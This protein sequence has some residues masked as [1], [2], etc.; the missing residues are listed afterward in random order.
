[1]FVLAVVTGLLAGGAAGQASDIKLKVGQVWTYQGAELEESRLTIGAIQD[2]PEGRIIHVQIAPIP[3]KTVG[4]GHMIGGMVGHMPFAEEVVL[5]NLLTLEATGVSVDP[6]FK[7]G[8][9]QWQDANGG[10]F[11]ITPS[12]AVSLV[13]EI[14]TTGDWVEEGS[15]K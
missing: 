1:M 5:E 6:M 3:M 15:E 12:Q 10:V 4:D 13:Y 14:T 7:G 8:F 9:Q 2:A 11:T